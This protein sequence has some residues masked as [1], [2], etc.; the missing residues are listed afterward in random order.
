[1]HGK[2]IIK[3][4]KSCCY[5]S[6]ILCIRGS[7][8]GT[9]AWLAA[10]RFI[11]K[12]HGSSGAVISCLDHQVSCHAGVNAAAHGNDCFFLHGIF[13]LFYMD[14]NQVKSFSFDVAMVSLSTYDVNM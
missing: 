2:Y 9:V 10:L 7:A 14:R 3:D 1:M 4:S 8:A 13:S 12:L 5:I 6:R 11:I